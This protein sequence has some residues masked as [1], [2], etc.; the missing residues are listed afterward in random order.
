MKVKLKGNF[1]S[2]VEEGV[3]GIIIGGRAGEGT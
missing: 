3:W 2:T 1:V